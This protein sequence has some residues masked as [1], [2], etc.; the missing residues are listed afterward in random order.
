VGDE[1]GCVGGGHV[2]VQCGDCC[3]GGRRR[4]GV[5][6]S[7]GGCWEVVR[8]KV[9][10]KSVLFANNDLIVELTNTTTPYDLDRHWVQSEGPMGRTLE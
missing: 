8:C 10:L 5:C 4:D 2:M 9:E 1:C 6:M 3:G 7:V